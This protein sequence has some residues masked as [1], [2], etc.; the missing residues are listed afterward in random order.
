MS[1]IQLHQIKTID[2]ETTSYCNL[3]CPQCDRFDRKGRENKY[4]ELAHLDFNRIGK[5]LMLDQLTGLE[6]ILLEGD[7]GDPLMH[8]DIQGI[9]EFFAKVKTVHLV[10]NASLRDTRWW[11]KLAAQKNLTVTFSIDGLADTLD[12]YRINADFDKIMAN[13]RAFISAGGRARWK[14]IVFHHNEHQVEAA[15]SLSQQLGFEQFEAKPSNRNFYEEDK[16]PIYVD[17]QYQGRVLQMSSSVKSRSPSYKV[18]LQKIDSGQYQSPTCSWLQRGAIYIDYLGNVIPCCMTS[19][20]MW[21]K[22]I[23]GQLW[24]RLIGDVSAVNLYHHDITGIL[25]SEFYQNNLENSF[26]DVK[27][28]HHACV[29]NCS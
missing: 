18:M 4:M 26:L 8:P 11:Q 1:L 14:F 16:L 27:T 29:S 28:V 2:I 22:D 17:G 9:I 12:F 13:A 10:T 25:Q 19:G 7:H 15:R 3:H 21:R 20:L 23:S 24:Q 5:N 6:Q